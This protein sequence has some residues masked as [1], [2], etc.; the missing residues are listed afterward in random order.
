MSLVGT[1]GNV[2]RT[3]WRIYILMIGCKGL[4]KLSLSAPK[5]VLEKI[6]KNV[7]TD[8]RVYMV[9]TEQWSYMWVYDVRFG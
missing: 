5:E 2:S 8:V 1:L 3:V 4:N 7:E 6:M 9:N